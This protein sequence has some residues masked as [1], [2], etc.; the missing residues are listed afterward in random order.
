MKWCLTPYRQRTDTYT[1]DMS[2]SAFP[3]SKPAAAGAL[4]L[5]LLLPVPRADSRPA[6]A[7]QVGPQD[8]ALTQLV[9]AL[10]Q[11][12]VHLD[13]AAGALWIPVRIEVRDE[14]LEYLLV[15]NSG[16]THESLFSTDVP[17]SVL[18]TA[19]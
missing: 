11:Q 7:P 6:Q 1:P 17:A 5:A 15:G 12:G 13:P 8:P 14:L 16:A 19:L 3:R 9:E 10:R 2:I 18:N 4:A